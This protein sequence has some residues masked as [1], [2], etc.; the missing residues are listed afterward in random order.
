MFAPSMEKILLDS[1]H[2]KIYNVSHKDFEYM[3]VS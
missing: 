2:M 1:R 3:G